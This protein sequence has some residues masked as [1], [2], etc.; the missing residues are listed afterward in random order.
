MVSVFEKLLDSCGETALYLH[1]LL[2][3][4]LHYRIPLFFSLMFRP[5]FSSLD[6]LIH[7]S[8]VFGQLC[9]KPHLQVQAGAEEQGLHTLLSAGLLFIPSCVATLS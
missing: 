4:S 7:R 5:G 1:F 3:I 8:L 2:S 9:Y 6:I